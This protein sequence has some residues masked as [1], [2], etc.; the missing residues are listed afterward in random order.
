MR[1]LTGLDEAAGVTIAAELALPAFVDLLA[2]SQADP[3]GEA[4]GKPA[5]PQGSCRQLRRLLVLEGVQDPGNLGTLLRC[6]T[7]FGWDAVLAL[8]TPLSVPMVG[9]ME[10]LNVG[11]AGAILMFALSNGGLEQLWSRLR[12]LRLC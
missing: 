4:G 11:V 10:S 5:G 9:D 2:G 1:K 12:Q 6:A 7:A 8:A 3:G